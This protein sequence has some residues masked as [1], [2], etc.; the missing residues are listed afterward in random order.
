[1]A[2]VIRA[3]GKRAAI[4]GT[5]SVAF[6]SDRHAHWISGASKNSITRFA[7]TP[8]AE[9]LAIEMFRRFG[10]IPTDQNNTSEQRNAYASR[11]LTDFLWRD[12]VPEFSFLWLSEPDLAQHDYSPGAKLSMAAIRSSDRNLANI[13]AAL[14]RKNARD[15][16]DIFI[17]SDHGFSTIERSID[18]PGVLRDAGFDA[19]VAFEQSPKSGQIM[20]VGNGGTVLFYVVDHDHDVTSRLVDWLQQSDFAGVIFSREKHDGTFPL[21]A[22]RINTPY[23]PDVLVALRWNSKSNRFG[24]RGQI[25]TD[26]ARVADEGSHATLSEFDVHNTLIAAGPDFRR[27]MENDLPSGNIDLAPTI[28][29]ILGL[30]SEHKLDGRVLFEAMIAGSTP[31][32]AVT[33]TLEASRTLSV[34]EWRQYLCTSR[35]G[36]TIYFDEGNGTFSKG[37]TSPLDR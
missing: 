1:M 37:S 8:L 21:D 16:T 24:V 13:L 7:T 29:H 5:K 25:T 33:E 36:D 19:V 15:K 10:P 2:E 32:H 12:G 17:V 23:A 22:A 34:G 31:S 11:A 4:V 35:V 18:F 9:N 14:S 26:A 3:A 27:G 28:L 6:L 30:K 20:V